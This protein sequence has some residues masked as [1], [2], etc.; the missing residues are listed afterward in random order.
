MEVARFLRGSCCP[1]AVLLT[2]SCAGSPP[3]TP[4]TAATS[5]S[6]QPLRLCLQTKRDA[7][8]S[9]ALH[10]V[11]RKTTKVDY[12]RI[13]Y[14]QAAETLNADTD[15]DALD[16]LVLLPNERCQRVIRRPKGGDVAIYFLFSEPKGQWKRLVD[17]NVRGALEFVVAGNQILVSD[18]SLACREND[19]A[20]A[21]RQPALRQ[22]RTASP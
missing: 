6:S 8:G 19:D 13:D 11:V 20:A 2:I 4:S 18:Q 17:A 22:C 21:H 5:D 7:N 12:P 14:A 1:L 15:P 9:S 16:W 10:V 3:L